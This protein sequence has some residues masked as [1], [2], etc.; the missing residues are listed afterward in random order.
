MM[1]TSATSTRSS[2]API[3]SATAA[4]IAAS[5]RSR[6]ANART[7]SP[8]SESFWLAARMSSRTSAIG[9]CS[10]CQSAC[11]QRSSDDVGC[12]LDASRSAA[13]RRIRAASHSGRSWNVAMNLYSESNGTSARRG[14]AAP[15]LLG[16]DAHLGGEH[17]ERGLGR[18][19]DDGAVVAHRRVACRARGR[20]PGGGSRAARPPA[21]PRIAPVFA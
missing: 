20:A 6:A 1:P 21:T 14:S 12:A 7:R 18:V 11:V 15:G 8:C 19:A 10:P 16:V 17:H 5:S 9:T 2:T 3:G 4:A 13:R